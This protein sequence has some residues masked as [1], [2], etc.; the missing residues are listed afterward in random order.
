MGAQ[1][2]VAEAATQSIL[3]TY[4]STREDISPGIEFTALQLTVDAKPGLP[5]EKERIRNAGGYVRRAIHDHD[6]PERVWLD[7]SLQTP[8]L[9]MSRSLGDA[10]A[11]R[12]GV[13][14]TP[15]ISSHTLSSRDQFLVLATDGVWDSLSNAAVV[16]SIGRAVS[17]SS[18]GFAPE[19]VVSGVRDANGGACIDDTTCVIVKLPEYNEFDTSLGS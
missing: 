2:G 18:L 19:Q 12:V 5:E 4:L 11:R 10:I 3:Q 9:A 16:A 13:I 14:P 1:R 15:M 6:G 17:K 8:G 7:S